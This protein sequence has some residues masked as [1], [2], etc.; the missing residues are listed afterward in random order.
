[1]TRYPGVVLLAA[2]ASVSVLVAFLWTARSRRR[3]SV[4]LVP[5]VGRVMR[6][7]VVRVAIH[8][9][10]RS[11]RGG[12]FTL[13]VPCGGAEIVVPV[14][15]GSGRAAAPLEID[16]PTDRRGELVIGPPAIAHRD[17][18]GLFDRR[19]QVGEPVAVEV[20][21][22]ILPV[23]IGR[24]RGR[25]N[26]DAPRQLGGQ[27][28]GV[29]FASLR[30]YQFGDDVRRVHWLASRRR[31]DGTLLI[32]QN[33]DP[34]DPSIEV[35]L[36]TDP[37]AYRGPDASAA[38]ETAVDVSASI[39]DSTRRVGAAATLTVVS[40]ETARTPHA[41]DELLRTVGLSPGRA[42]P[43]LR[44]A[45]LFTVVTGSGGA[46]D[47]LTAVP[48]GRRSVVVRVDV[49]PADLPVASARW[50]IVDAADLRSAL[51]GWARLA[52]AATRGQQ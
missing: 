33:V 47:L 50:A 21:P 45:G 27:E 41:I 32:R 2:G 48:P 23:E 42:V 51:A 37:A 16:V 11:A 34:V 30:E 46:S 18:L 28:G 52:A 7:E 25:Q 13:V 43:A 39:L 44:P 19:E 9:T 20:G 31:A 49:R 10:R 35:L 4:S 15:R 8:V 5:A 29:N 26:P 6:G 40:G 3:A 36:D 22:R 17:L 14:R 1:M 38:F 24:A 12:A